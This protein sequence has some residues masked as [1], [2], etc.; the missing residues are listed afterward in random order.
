M[1][2]SVLQVAG[3]GSHRVSGGWSPA[4][5]NMGPW[6]RPALLAA[7]ALASLAP[8]HGLKIKYDYTAAELTD[9][10]EDTVGTLFAESLIEM[11][12]CVF[13]VF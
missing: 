12:S 5:S 8:V 6:S 11:I 1:A 10:I 9:F 4:A 7:L 2:T 13:H 3:A